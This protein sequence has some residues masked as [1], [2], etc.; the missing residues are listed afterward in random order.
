MTSISP[1]NAG[2]LPPD[3]AFVVQLQAPGRQRIE[4]M[5]GRVEHIASGQTER[6]AS[7]FELHA[8]MR[9][10]SLLAELSTVMDA[11][12]RPEIGHD[13]RNEDLRFV[14]D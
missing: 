4:E 1:L 6:F 2:S 12:A 9:K 3:R 8:F 11:T 10:C 7:L 13:G 14:R 5:S